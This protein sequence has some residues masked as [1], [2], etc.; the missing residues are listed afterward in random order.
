VRRAESRGPALSRAGRPARRAERRL[1]TQ[2]LHRLQ[3]CWR[4]HGVKRRHDRR[5]PCC[6][7]EPT[8]CCT[9]RQLR[10]RSAGPPNQR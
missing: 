6:P 7:A 10:W 3:A 2:C 1:R 5:I 4:H 9:P 8:V